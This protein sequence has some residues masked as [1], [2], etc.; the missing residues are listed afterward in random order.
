MNI[1]LRPVS[2]NGISIL[3]MNGAT[4]QGG[5]SQVKSVI[6]QLEFRVQQLF[7]AAHLPLRLL[8]TLV[9]FILEASIVSVKQQWNKNKS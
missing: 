3:N 5:E 2:E 8:F 7:S 4:M 9:L 1:W 6:L